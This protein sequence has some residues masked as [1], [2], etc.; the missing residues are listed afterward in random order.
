MMKSTIFSLFIFRHS[1]GT[2]FVDHLLLYRTLC[3]LPNELRGQS[4]FSALVSPAEK[5]EPKKTDALAG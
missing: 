4:V 1:C 5:L 3:R 2:V